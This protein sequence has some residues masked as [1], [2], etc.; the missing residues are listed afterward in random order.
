MTLAELG[1]ADR[2]ESQL[3]SEHAA[4]VAATLNSVAPPASGELPLLWHWAFFPPIVPTSH[5]GPD[6]HPE[7]FGPLATEFPRRMWVGGRVTAHAP[8][9]TDTPTVLRTDLVSS[10]R[11]SGSTGELLL[12]TLRHRIEQHGHCV[13]EERQDVVYRRGGSITAPAG[14]AVEMPPGSSVIT[15]DPAQLFRFSAVTFNSH[16]IHYDLPY[17]TGVEGYPG[18]VVHGP[19][20]AM[21]LER[22]A[23][24]ALRQ[25]IRTFSFRA[26]APLFASAPVALTCALA[27]GAASLT[28]VRQDGVVAMTATAA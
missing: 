26:T 19:F 1:I 20:T 5:L 8:P 13:I 14:P 9:R 16:R 18:L 10:E 3:P 15:P 2:S 23:A 28:A 4:R 27:D 22:V 24:A 6:G 17:A 12:V 25:P 11:K 7:R 21:L